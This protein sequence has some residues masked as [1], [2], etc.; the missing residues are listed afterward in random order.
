MSERIRGA[1]GDR[2]RVSTRV[3]KVSRALRVTEGVSVENKRRE[4]MGAVHQQSQP[5]IRLAFTL[6]RKHTAN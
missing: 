6:S 5:L 3:R 4:E 2:T 1:N